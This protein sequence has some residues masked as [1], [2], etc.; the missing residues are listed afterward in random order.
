M[1]G[2]G[3]EAVTPLNINA[4]AFLQQAVA[5]SPDIVNPNAVAAMTDA[6]RK[7]Q[8][9]ADDIIARYGDVAKAKDKAEIQGLH[10]FISPE[11]IASRKASIDLMGEKAKSELATIP[12]AEKARVAEYHATQLK[13][14]QGDAVSMRA[15]AI[16][17]G[18]AGSLSQTA[19]GASYSNAD[20]DKDA[21]AY[22]AAVR[23]E[24]ATKGAETFLKDVDVEKN[25]VT[26]ADGS[27]ERHPE[28]DQ[29]FSK[30]S[31]VPFTQEQVAAAHRLSQMT[32]QQFADAGYPTVD[33]YVF[34]KE[35]TAGSTADRSNAVT[36]INKTVIPAKTIVTETT[37]AEG[38]K[39]VR[40]ETVEG[41]RNPN[42]DAYAVEPIVGPPAPAAAKPMLDT[43]GGVI[44]AAPVK[45]ETE[46]DLAQRIKGIRTADEALTAFDR[47]EKLVHDE[48]LKL[49]GPGM[50]EGT[51]PRQI[52]NRIGAYFGSEGARAVLAGQSQL[53]QFLAQSIQNT[54]RSLAGTGN[55]VMQAEISKNP[56][57]PG[58]FIQAQPKLTDTPETWDVWLKSV[59]DFVKA[60]RE[61]D[62]SL[63]P[64][65]QQKK[66]QTSTPPGGGGGS[67]AAKPTGQSFTT[68][69]G[70]TYVE[71]PKR[72]GSFIMA[73]GASSKA[74]GKP[75]S[76]IPP[77][78]EINKWKSPS[79][80]QLL[81]PLG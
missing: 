68:K 31:S 76:V 4:N 27:V 73:P 67:T 53:D 6:F 44:K 2:I 75:E 16:K 47:A 43:R 30:T 22:Q 56:E 35:P 41:V 46:K 78:S 20:R 38:K 55:R 60:G 29:P 17:N 58:L 48:D 21:K 23:Y 37:D 11:A 40:T 77:D 79:F 25:Q 45:P 74:T 28:K 52:S 51:K 66:Y 18:Y 70:I 63:L 59:R 36:P 61:D 8:I 71:D 81:T 19:P 12:D 42:P 15:V 14:E 3:A 9:S 69:S 7:G 62:V 26:N 10:E 54:I 33:S 24:N 32:P 65:E 13:A 72:P 64:P 1:P 34:G 57:D 5:P 80:F 49:V 50:G 39:T